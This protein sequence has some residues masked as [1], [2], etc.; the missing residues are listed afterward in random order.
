M[1]IKDIKNILYKEKNKDKI[2]MLKMS[3]ELSKKL[4][5]RVE[6][7]LMPNNIISVNVPRPCG[8]CYISLRE[9]LTLEE[10]ELEQIVHKLRK[11]EN[12]IIKIDDIYEFMYEIFIDLS[13]KD[14]MKQDIIEII[15]NS[16][17]QK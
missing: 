13:I 12:A 9:I 15:R 16:P 10:Q 3:K 17:Y 2:F 11:V 4:G 6:L 7:C 14:F 8:C 1:E 5:T